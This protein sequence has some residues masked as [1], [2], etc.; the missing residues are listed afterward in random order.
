MRNKNEKGFTTFIKSEKI[1]VCPLCNKDVFNNQLF[2][3][4]DELYHLSCYNYSK[5]DE[6]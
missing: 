6:E 5:A 3:K 4:E 1:G 2:V